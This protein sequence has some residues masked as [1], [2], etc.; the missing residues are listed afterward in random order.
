MA[1]F[2]L[3]STVSQGKATQALSMDCGVFDTDLL[4]VM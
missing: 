4:I 3:I 1:I 2:W